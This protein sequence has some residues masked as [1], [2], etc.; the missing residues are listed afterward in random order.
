[1]LTLK[2][3]IMENKQHTWLCISKE[4]ELHLFEDPSI[5]IQ[6][7]KGPAPDSMEWKNSNPDDDFAWIIKGS[8]KSKLTVA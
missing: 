4:E 7:V 1:M 8:V 5:S 6:E 2:P 3:I